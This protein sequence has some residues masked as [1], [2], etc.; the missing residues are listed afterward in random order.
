M[1]KDITL[2]KMRINRLKTAS[3]KPKSGVG[4]INCFFWSLKM[5]ILGIFFVLFLGPFLLVLI[6]SFKSIA[7]FISS[8]LALPENLDLSNYIHAFQRMNFITSFWHSL[9][10]AVG[11]VALIILISSMAAYIFA[12]MKW[13]FMFYIMVAS[14]FIP[15]QSI[16][17]PLVGVYGRLSLLNNQWTLIFMYMGFGTALAVMFYHGFIKGIPLELEEAAVIDGCSKYQTFF[18]I[19][20]PLLTPVTTTIIILD[21]LWIWNDYLLPVLVLQSSNWKTLP[22]RVYSFFGSY[23]VQYTL[24]YAGLMMSMLPAVFVYL[25]LQKYIVKGIIQGAIK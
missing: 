24:L 20:F 21:M 7:A 11:S 25:L 12:R 22:M 10:I 6:N 1:K 4:G 16:M 15:F 19:V 18:K 13:N 17:I 23:S 2:D 5:I 14:M 3:F 8:P 9:F